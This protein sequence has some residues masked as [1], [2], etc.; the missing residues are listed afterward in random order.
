MKELPS[1]CLSSTGDMYRI[2]VKW[3]EYAPRV[4]EI[5]PV[6][7]A[8]MKGFV[9]IDVAGCLRIGSLGTNRKH[10]FVLDRCIPLCN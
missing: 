4:V 8:E 2:V 10:R 7:F 3:C 9:S 5:H 1:H 6:L